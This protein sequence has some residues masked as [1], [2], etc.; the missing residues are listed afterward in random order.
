MVC[1]RYQHVE[2]LAGSQRSLAKSKN[3][4]AIAHDKISNAIRGYRRQLARTWK[5]L[6][7][8]NNSLQGSFEKTE[9]LGSTGELSTGI[10]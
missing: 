3:H 8:L 7:F 4:Y 9:L 6:F 10:A 5:T 2:W 1:E